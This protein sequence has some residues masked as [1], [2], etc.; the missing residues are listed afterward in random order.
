MLLFNGS[1][2]GLSVDAP[3][4]FRGMTIGRVL[5]IK[6]KLDMDGK[7]ASI[8]VLV[9]IEP[10]RFDIEGLSGDRAKVV[11]TLLAMGLRAQ[12]RSG[13]L[14]TGSAYVDMD[15]H[16]EL[17]PGKLKTGKRFPELPTMPSPL[18]GIL[19]KA[20][21]IMN[22]VD[23]VP[24]SALSSELRETMGNIRETMVGVRESMASFKV[25]MDKTDDQRVLS[26]AGAMMDQIN[27]TMAKLDKTLDP[28][29]D[30]QAD[31][32]RLLRELTDAARSLR[33]L[34]DYLERQPDALL[35]GK[36]DK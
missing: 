20:A 31:T 26:R 33:M 18:E 15:L 28:D 21:S 30:L 36:D 13:N 2:R 27:A 35:Y 7:V 6:L 19:I 14:V 34:V 16:P 17:P 32:G 4:E 29:S 8:P 22:K 11:P 3:V 24:F 12:L 25:V 1:V 10:E 23:K 9:E 5:D